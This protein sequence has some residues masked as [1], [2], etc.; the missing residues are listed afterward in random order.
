MAE[1]NSKL[2]LAAFTIETVAHLQ[3]HEA[4]LLPQADFV[5]ELDKVLK[6]L[7]EYG[8]LSSVLAELGRLAKENES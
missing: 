3:A 4:M 2:H 5:R 8:P 6:R 1:Q 7:K